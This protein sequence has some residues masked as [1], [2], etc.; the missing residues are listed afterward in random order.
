MKK[1]EKKENIILT[2]IV[3][4]AIVFIIHVILKPDEE[5]K[6]INTEINKATEIEVSSKVVRAKYINTNT[7]ELLPGSYIRFNPNITF[8]IEL[9]DDNQ[10]DFYPVDINGFKFNGYYE[11]FK[12]D[13]EENKNVFKEKTFGSHAVIPYQKDKQEDNCYEVVFYYDKVE[14]S[15]VENEQEIELT[16]DIMNKMPDLKDLN[17]Y[18]YLT[19]KKDKKTE[20]QE[21]IITEIPYVIE[22][23]QSINKEVLNY[24]DKIYFAIGIGENAGKKIIKNDEK[25]AEIVFK[26]VDGKYIFSEFNSISNDVEL[27]GTNEN[28]QTILVNYSPENT[29]ICFYQLV[30]LKNNVVVP[31]KDNLKANLFLPENEKNN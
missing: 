17:V 18:T 8:F 13:S 20:K 1:N 27:L 14:F 31:N 4:V 9:V 11:V 22:P 19:S 2:F 7:N 29:G 15:Q 12:I 21:T 3:I 10:A 23:K 16:D 24:I 25:V 30:V 26:I 28:G 6:T 5:I